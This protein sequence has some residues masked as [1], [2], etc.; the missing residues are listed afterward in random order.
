[1]TQYKGPYINQWKN[2]EYNTSVINYTYVTLEF[3]QLKNYAVY[4]EKYPDS[5][6]TGLVRVGGLI[7]IL[8]LAIF[9]N[10]LNRKWFHESL[11]DNLKNCDNPPSHHRND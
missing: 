7:A 8:R 4:Y 2:L 3:E 10:L 6:L 5:F 9:L 1:M 11:L